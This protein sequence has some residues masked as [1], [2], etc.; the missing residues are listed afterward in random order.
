MLTDVLVLSKKWKKGDKLSLLPTLKGGY[1]HLPIGVKSL[2][3][4][5][6]TLF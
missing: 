2:A 5:L 6:L 3:H 4:N 1:I